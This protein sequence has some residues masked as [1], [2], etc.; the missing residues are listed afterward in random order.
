MQA[1]TSKVYKQI[2]YYPFGM[3]MPNRT[4]TSGNYRYGFNGKE[5]DDE[6]S[7][8]IEGAD[9]DY[10]ARIYDSRIGRFLSIDSKFKLSPELTPY[11]FGLNNP[12]IFKDND[13]NWEEDGHYWTV[14]ALGV[15]MGLSKEKAQSI[16]ARAE[17]YDHH[18]NSS[19]V[20][21]F[22]G[23]G[24]RTEAGTDYGL[25]TWANPE[26]QERYHGL[27]GRAQSEVIWWAYSRIMFDGDLEALHTYGDAWAHSKDNTDNKMMYGKKVGWLESL[28]ISFTMEHAFA[29]DG[30]GPDA[31][32]IAKRGAAYLKYVDGLTGLFNDRMFPEKVNNSNPDLSVFKF[33]S[34][35]GTDKSEN[36]FLLSKFIDI[37]SGTNNFRFTDKDRYSRNFDLFKKYLNSA[38]IEFEETTEWK[39]NYKT[40]D[41]VITLK[42]KDKPKK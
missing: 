3:V 41:S 39:D 17:E 33:I 5:K 30:I 26:S 22:N 7:G 13:G 42:P 11:R 20:F 27:T 12:I 14:Y 10:G 37:Q 36:I 35:A 23:F 4:A 18:V 9:Y 29:D 1:I 15:A 40:F 28:G 38:G 16:A 25:G 24:F 32:K 31:D 19:G 6:I 2:N 8:G 21:S 34:S